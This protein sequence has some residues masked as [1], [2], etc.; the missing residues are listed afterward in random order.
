M[1]FPYPSF[2]LMCPIKG[3]WGVQAT[4]NPEAKEVL[5]SRPLEA[6]GECSRPLFGSFRKLGV[7]YFGVLLIRILLFRVLH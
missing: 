7:P 4:L 6:G 2:L 3:S 1:G 5:Q